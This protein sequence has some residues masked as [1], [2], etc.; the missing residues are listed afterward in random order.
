MPTKKD[1]SPAQRTLFHFK[2]QS[3]KYFETGRKSQECEILFRPFWNESLLLPLKM[4][5][6]SIN[7]SE[8]SSSSNNNNNNNNNNNKNNTSSFL[9]KEQSVEAKPFGEEVSRE[10]QRRGESNGDSVLLPI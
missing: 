1:P 6:S 3:R 9:G 8:N 5:L 2:N 10:R 4:L 7:Y